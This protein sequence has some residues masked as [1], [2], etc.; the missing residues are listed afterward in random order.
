MSSATKRNRPIQPPRD[1]SMGE[2]SFEIDKIIEEKIE[3]AVVA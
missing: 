3:A 1:L 2:I